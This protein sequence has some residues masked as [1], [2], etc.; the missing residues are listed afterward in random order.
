MKELKSLFKTME[1][2]VTSSNERFEKV[3]RDMNEA[4]DELQIINKLFRKVE[5]K[6][7]ADEEDK[8]CSFL[9]EGVPKKK[10]AKS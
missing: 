2:N 8:R 6:I 10:Q 3:E 7:N 5:A 9:L 1:E 4:T